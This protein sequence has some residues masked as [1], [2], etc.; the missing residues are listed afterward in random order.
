MRRYCALT[1][2]FLDAVLR[3]DDM[4]IYTDC[5]FVVIACIYLTLLNMY[6]HVRSLPDM[7]LEAERGNISICRVN[8]MLSNGTGM[9]WNEC[10]QIHMK[11]VMLK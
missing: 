1:D 2:V 7:L 11:P 10:T 8:S 9:V 5:A 6:R 4:S 3:V